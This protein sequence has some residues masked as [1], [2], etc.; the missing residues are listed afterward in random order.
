MCFGRV[1][2]KRGDGIFWAESL[3]TQAKIARFAKF[4]DLAIKST[5]GVFLLH[6]IQLLADNFIENNVQIGH[7]Q[8]NV[9][10]LWGYR[11]LEDGLLKGK[12]NCSALRSS[13]LAATVMSKTGHPC[14]HLCRCFQSSRV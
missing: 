8:G 11:P 6:P 9:C 13:D 2:L 12:L 5:V 3:R 14:R 4:S 1:A 7:I 10:G